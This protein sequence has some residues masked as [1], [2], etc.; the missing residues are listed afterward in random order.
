LKNG[1]TSDLA[2]LTEDNFMIRPLILAFLVTAAFALPAAAA[3]QC[4]K[5]SD[6]QR[7]S[8]LNDKLNALVSILMGEAREDGSSGGGFMLVNPG[9]ATN[10]QCLTNGATGA[11]TAPKMQYCDAQQATR[12]WVVAPKPK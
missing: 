10:N 5:G 1:D 7:I 3:E 2:D 6:E 11:S 12:I 9:Q 8:C 4:D